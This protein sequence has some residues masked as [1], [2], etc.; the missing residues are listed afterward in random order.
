MSIFSDNIRFLRTQKN[1]SQQ[2]LAD[3]ISMSRVRYSK[4]E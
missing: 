4:Y 1:V 2:E 3:Q